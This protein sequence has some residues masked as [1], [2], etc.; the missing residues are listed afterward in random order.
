MLLKRALPAT[1]REYVSQEL[2]REKREKTRTASLAHAGA[3]V[4]N[5][6]RVVVMYMRFRRKW[7]IL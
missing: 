7:Q 3:I 2:N 5:L 1:V 4:D 6:T